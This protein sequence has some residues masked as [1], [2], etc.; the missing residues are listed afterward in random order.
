MVSG[1]VFQVDKAAFEGKEL[2]GDKRKRGIQPDWVA[3]ILTILIWI[4]RT[5]D[6]ITISPY[7]LMIM[8]KSVLLAKNSLI[9]FCTNISPPKPHAYSLQ[10][11]LEGFKC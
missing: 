10:P 11:F 6:G 3:L 8:M 7:E 2:L 1:I 4:N 9:G 5:L